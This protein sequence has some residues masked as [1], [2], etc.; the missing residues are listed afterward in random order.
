[1]K[2]T[3]M[4]INAPYPSRKIRRIRAL[5]FTQHPRREDFY[6]VSRRNPY[7]VLDY[8]S[9][10][11]LEYNNCGAYAKKPQYAV[12][13]SFNTVYRPVFRIGFCG[14]DNC[15][16]TG[17]SYG[18]AW[19]GGLGMG[20]DMG[21]CKNVKNKDTYVLNDDAT[22]GKHVAGSSSM[23]NDDIVSGNKEDTRYITRKI[24]DTKRQ[25]LEGVNEK[26]NS[27]FI[28]SGMNI[29]CVNEGIG[30]PSTMNVN[31]ESSLNTSKATNTNVGPGL[32]NN[33]NLNS[34]PT[35]VASTSS[36]SFATLLK[37]EWSVLIR[38]VPLIQR[39][40]A[41]NENIM[42]EDVCNIPHWMKFHDIPISAFMDDGLNII[43]TKLDKPHMLGFYTAAMCTN[44]WGKACYSWVHR[45]SVIGVQVSP[46]VG[47]KQNKKVYRPVSQKNGA[48]TS[49]KKVDYA[50]VNSNSDSD[51]EVAYDKT[52]QFMA[53][54]GSNDASV[55]KDEDYDIY[56]TYDIIDKHQLKCNSHKDAKTL[57]EAI[58]KRFGG[59]TET[60]KVQK[61]LLKQQ[62]ENFSGS[63]SEGLDQI[64]DRLQK[65]A[66]LEEHRLDDL[67]N[68]LKIYEAKF[69]HSSSPGNPKQN[70]SFVSSSNT[71]ST[72]DSVS[73]ATSVFVIFAKLH[74]SSHPNI[75]SLSNAVIFLFFASQSTSPQ[76]DNEDLKH[77]DVDDLEE[78]PTSGPTS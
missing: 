69:K 59:N 47:F 48:S 9:W 57:M 28:E 76:L 15:L 41:P 71:D 20:K 78:S 11:I 53:N 51:L 13:I 70:L 62:F 12:L 14:L 56:N 54:G 4:T 8:K 22:M 29:E 43:S 44:S 16:F 35:V 37:G 17:N 24:N 49:A 21:G 5:N 7:A 23:S 75:D 64:H 6:I 55:Y 68:S 65:L 60:N 50:L 39:K 40:R 25:M 73:A 2:S 67:F 45:Q 52:T 72:T 63:S 77:I 74:V 46:K 38:N 34:T 61:T 27:F 58:K 66:D 3:V 1:M 18:L 19:K 33:P 30:S 42:M 26:Q 31:V 32:A 36:V 10:N